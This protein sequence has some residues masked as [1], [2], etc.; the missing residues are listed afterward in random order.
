MDNEKIKNFITTQRQSG[1]PDTEIYSFLQSKGIITDTGVTPQPKE[2]KTFL[3]KVADFTGG[4]EI[5][6]GLGQAMAQPKIS[7]QI[8]QVQSDQMRI[9]GDLI[10]KIRE[11]R[12]IGKDTSRLEVALKNLTGEMQTT[13]EEAMKLLNQAELT[14]KQ[15]IGDALQLATTIVGAGTL[16]SAGAKVVGAK[17]FGQGLVQGA[18]TGAITGGAFGASTGASQALQEDKSIGG[19]AKDTLGGA[20]M[21]AGT[22]GI[23]GGLTGGVTGAIRGRK[24]AQATQKK[25]FVEDL[26][27]PKLTTAVKEQAL[28][29]GRVTEQ[30]LLSA[31]KIN[32]SKRDLDLAEAVKD[33]VNP[34]KS[35]LENINIID[36]NLGEI[37][38]GVKAYVSSK[39]VPFNTNQLTS[40]LNKGKDELK[41]IFAGDKQ[42][43]KT[44]NAVV[45]EFLKNVKSKDTAGLFEA[46][47]KF[48]QIPAIKKLLDSQGL[49]EN[50]KKEIVLTVRGKANEYVA[51]LLPKGNKF[52]ETLLKESKMIEAIQ[53]M[54][55][56]GATSIG[57]NRLQE[58]TTKYPILKAVAGGIAGGLGLGAVGVGSSIIGSSD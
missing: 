55:E 4:K 32:P 14:D 29:E 10:N 2:K 48:D 33:I 51:S 7:K 25:E 27:A 3:E 41:L 6:Q 9:Q 39:K 36:K 26:V 15:V 50:V 8:E 21:G 13:G 53:N 56:K 37:N 17:T 49:G 57:K 28:K 22:G 19:I 5:A 16:P 31:S 23:L 38:T 35:L 42:A 30:G 1:I 40:Q 54:A 58:L 12:A 11:N 34:K 43:E 52:R 18:K 24:V 45:K 47:Q 44:Y 46:R 20:L